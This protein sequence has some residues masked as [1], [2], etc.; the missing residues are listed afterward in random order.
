M[1]DTWETYILPA[2][3]AVLTWI[4]WQWRRQDQRITALETRQTVERDDFER[5]ITGLRDDMRE[6]A[7]GIHERLDRLI[8][9][10]ISR[11]E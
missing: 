7:K 11:R 5:T 8:E 3:V 10:G 9:A 4:G 1:R 2:L 6:D